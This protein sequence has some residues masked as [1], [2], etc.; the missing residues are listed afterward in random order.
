MSWAISRIRLSQIGPATARYEGILDLRAPDGNPARAVALRLVNQGGKGVLLQHLLNVLVP[1]QRGI[2]GEKETWTK[3]GKFVLGG[4]LAH[5]AI[6]WRRAD[7]LLITGKTMRWRHGHPSS[8]SRDLLVHF[9]CFRPDGLTLDNLP[10]IRDGQRLTHAAFHRALA[11][12][13][14]EHARGDHDAVHTTEHGK[15]VAALRDRG[16]DSD[17]F[18]YQVRMN[19]QE[20]GADQLLTTLKTNDAFLR[21][22]VEILAD[23]DDLKQ[24]SAMVAA[25]RTALARRELV[26]GEAGVCQALADAAA[27]LAALAA[28]ERAARERLGRAQR[29]AQLLWLALDRTRAAADAQAPDLEV[30]RRQATS[31]M[32]SA[33]REQATARLQGADAR[34]QLAELQLDAAD[35]DLG[36]RRDAVTTLERQWNGWRA[37]GPMADV[38]SAEAQL[39]A[40]ATVEDQRNRDAAPLLTQAERMGALLHR[41]LTRA[42]ETLDRDVSAAEARAAQAVTTQQDARARADAAHHT[43]AALQQRLEHARRQHSALER[44]RNRLVDDGVLPAGVQASDH[45]PVVVDQRDGTAGTLESLRDHLNTAEHRASATADARRDAAEDV[46]AAERDDDAARKAQRALNQE[47]NA[48][49]ELPGLAAALDQSEGSVSLWPDVE[50]T[51]ARLADHEQRAQL[52]LA[53]QLAEEHA[54]RE[55]VEHIAADEPGL[56]PPD[57]ECR[58]VLDHLLIRK[59]AAASGWRYVHESRPADGWHDALGRAGVLAAS[60]VLTAVDA[61]AADRLVAKLAGELPALRRPVALLTSD[62]FERLLA[63][64]PADGEIGQRAVTATPGLADPLAA[65]HRRGEL[66]DELAGA[67]DARGELERALSDATALRLA[68]KALVGRY[69]D[70]P[71]PAASAKVADSE[72]HLDRARALY[73]P[74]VEAERQA[75][76]DLVALHERIDRADALQRQLDLAVARLEPV[77]E[78]ERRLDGD[79][80]DPRVIAALLAAQQELRDQARADEEVAHDARCEAQDDIRAH[81]DERQA[82]LDERSQ[83]TFVV[84]NPATDETHH[85]L[86]YHRAAYHAAVERWR[87][88]STDEQLAADRRRAE[89]D[90]ADAQ[91]RRDQFEADV[92]ALAAQ[93]LADGRAGSDRRRREEHAHRRLSDGQRAMGAAQSARNDAAEA[94]DS[95]VSERDRLEQE[96]AAAGQKRTLD[97]SERP[98]LASVDDARAAARS[99]EQRGADADRRRNR[100]ASQEAGLRDQLR[101]TQQRAATCRRLLGRLPEHPDPAAEAAALADD[102]DALDG[103]VDDAVAALTRTAD[104]LEA[105]NRERSEVARHLRRIAL[106]DRQPP[107]AAR[108]LRQTIVAHGEHLELAVWATATQPQIAA[109]AASS[110]QELAHLDQRTG[111][112]VDFYTQ[113]TARFTGLLRRLSSVSKMPEGLGGWSGRSFITAS[114]PTRPADAALRDRIERTLSAALESGQDSRLRGPDLLFRG[115]LA[116]CDERA[117]TIRFLKPDI[118]LPYQPV[119]LG[120]GMSGGQGVTAAVALYCGLANLRREAVSAQLTATGGGTLLLDNPFGKATS[121]ELLGIMFRVAD[122]LGVQLVCLTPSTE[123]A[124]VAQFPVLLQLRNSRGVRD[125]LRH[126][127]VQDTR[128][129]DALSG[130]G[131]AIDAVRL[132][133][134]RP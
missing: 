68:Y 103:L 125:G 42:V 133:R 11:D 122:R 85:D 91:Q 134:K 79:E 77:A 93:L 65:E 3:L 99:A 25:Q 114:L 41:A 38:A 75:A 56:V 90:L 53:G 31:E 120:E 8:D 13:L 82:R 113:L 107:D 2:I 128:Y 12:A 6:E 72:R 51:L 57:D 29:D 121:P 52:R 97:E 4:D 45:L 61:P 88:A 48:V 63:A 30:R 33:R 92:L 22:F 58:A 112:V 74:A 15:W 69:P 118:G 59:V 43:A 23:E 36:E 84:Q 96:L 131:D 119:A 55:I 109:R 54:H 106:D 78:A 64:Q 35:R 116:A 7:E 18:R 105:V 111:G 34:V 26:A 124:V 5:L 117:P 98:R 87:A 50:R 60:V 83:I 81:A 32:T 21:F 27:P 95:A 102:V 28:D 49:A 104:E 37:T 80:H 44:D 9:Y 86:H 129:R 101:V 67:A 46:A 123:D 66:E 94:H 39:R 19:H 73:R 110:A 126:V 40:I 24:L 10:F 62:E 1:G 47:I 20:G 16:I 115:I 89:A 70:D 108:Q 100:A 130:T 132:T 17:L 76:E 14:T 127:R 71:R